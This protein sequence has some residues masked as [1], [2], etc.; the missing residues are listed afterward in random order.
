[1]LRVVTAT[2]VAGV[3]PRRHA[4]GLHEGLGG[5]IT[6][7]QQRGYTR[8]HVMH[9][10]RRWQPCIVPV[11]IPLSRL[12]HTHASPPPRQAAADFLASEAGI[13]PELLGQVAC[14]YPALL[15]APVATELAPR[16][17]FLRGLG[18]EAPGLLRGVL[19]EDWY[20]W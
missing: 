6:T 11:R 9:L 13:A 1:M 5:R 4:L 17:A 7:R 14:Q 12:A 10:L 19:H 15:A 20:G 8:L 3:R 18:P 16:L 2:G